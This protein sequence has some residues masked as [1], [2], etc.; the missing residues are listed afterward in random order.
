MEQIQALQEMELK[1]NKWFGDGTVK[2]AS[3]LPEL[4]NNVI[5][6]GIKELDQALG[7]GGIPGG[8]VTEIYG[9]EMTG[10]T[11]LALNIAAQAQKKG[12]V[13]YIDADGGLS[14]YLMQKNGVK[15]KNFYVAKPETMEEAFNLCRTAAAGFRL[16]VIDTIAALSPEG[17]M[18]AYM[19][20]HTQELQSKLI[21]QFMRMMVSVL[22]NTGCALL[23]VNQTRT[24]LGIV[25]GDPARAVGGRALKYY[26]AARIETKKIVLRSREIG[27]RY[28]VSKNKCAV[29]G[30]CADVMAV[31]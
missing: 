8:R 2:H 26:A 11:A 9:H 12:A 19:G 15:K 17:E 6:T 23:L 1:L 24:K 25:Y 18:V 31:F 3:D 20:E 16:I 30:K 28:I 13:L 5:P 14:P 10:K 4:K 29:P 21:S 22:S 7:I 27:F